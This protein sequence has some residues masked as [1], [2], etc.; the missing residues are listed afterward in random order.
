MKLI[1]HRGLLEGPDKSKENRPDQIVAAWTKGYDCEIDLWVQ[2]NELWLGHDSPQYRVLENFLSMGPSWIH[3]KN[4]EALRY[5]VTT[6]FNYFW[7]QEDYYTLTSKG[8]IWTYPGHELTDL[9]IMVLPE[10]IDPSLQN[11]KDV[12][13]FGICSDFVL[14]IT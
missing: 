8:Y 11:T 1:A 9:S 2:H 10:L 4:L 6:E 12:N 13:C 7:H 5:L 14:A 3:A